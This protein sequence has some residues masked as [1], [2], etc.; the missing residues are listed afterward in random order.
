MIGQSKLR[1]REG[2][3]DIA[4]AGTRFFRGNPAAATDWFWGVADCPDMAILA[5]DCSASLCAIVGA[6]RKIRMVKAW[7]KLCR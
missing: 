4:V 2:N 6:C 3:H 1:A 5:P 7:L